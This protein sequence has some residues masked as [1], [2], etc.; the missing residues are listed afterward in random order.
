M[1]DPTSAAPRLS[2]LFTYPL[3]GARGLPLEQAQLDE[4]GFRHDRRWMVVDQD[5]GFVSQRSDPRLALLRPCIS[6][7]ALLLEAPGQSPLTLPLQPPQ[8]GA[9]PVRIWR[10]DV[11]AADAGDD[12]AHWI[13]SW[14]GRSARIVGFPSA[15]ERPVDPEYARGPRD[16]VAFVD[17]Y[18]CLLISQAALDELNRRLAQ[19][20]PMERFRPNLVVAGTAPHAEDGWR[21]IRVGNLAF[22]VVKP[23]ARCVVTTIDQRSA[24]PGDEPLRTLATY[25]KVGSKVMFGQNLIHEGPGSVR[26]GDIVEVQ[27]KVTEREGPAA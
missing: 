6:G 13:A 1:D 3:K 10:D 2:G 5:G 26:L 23:C 7:D 27:E 20:L 22:D 12:A 15:S 4:L 16:R 8:R 24:I 18:P 25:R 14:L 19:P 21:R 9:V 11:A 17:A